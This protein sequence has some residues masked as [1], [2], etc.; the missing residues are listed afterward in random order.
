MRGASD[1]I[2]PALALVLIA[3]LAAGWYLL[4]A[5]E[6]HELGKQVA[7]GAGFIANLVLWSEAGYFD[8]AA[9]TKPLLHLWSLGIE[10]QFYL[11]WPLLLVLA[12]KLRL[13]RLSLVLGITAISLALNI[14]VVGDDRVAAF[15]LPQTRFWELMIGAALAYYTING[16]MRLD[17]LAVMPWRRG[18]PEPASRLNGLISVVGPV[19]IAGAIAFLSDG[20]EFPGWRALVPT[21]GA[22]LVIAS[23]PRA[24]FNQVILGHPVLVFIGLISYPLYLWHWPLLTFGRILSSGTPPLAERIGLVACSVI[25]AYLTYALIER[26]V[27]RSRRPTVVAALLVA[28]TII[29]GFGYDLY[30]PGGAVGRYWLNQTMRSD[31]KAFKSYRSKYAQCSGALAPDKDLYLCLVSRPGAPDSALFGDSH[32]DHLFPGIAKLDQDNGWLLIGQPACPPLAGMRVFTAG[33]KDGCYDV[34]E[35]ALKLIVANR[36]IRRVVLAFFGP[37]YLRDAGSIVP[38]ADQPDPRNWVIEP[39]EARGPGLSRDKAFLRGLDDTVGRLEAADKSVIL[40]VDIPEL[41]FS[42]SDC[43]GR[44]F[45]PAKRPSCAIDRSEVEFA[46]EAISRNSGPVGACP[47]AA[48]L[49]RS[50]R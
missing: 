32:A 10:E 26:Q 8:S 3:C 49:L 35:A 40:Y 4:F 44:G 18:T 21:M 30:L 50:I 36:D 24:W 22:F 38:G 5:E 31:A 14:V 7:G 42:P 11:I 23:G 41:S 13:P 15:Y 1:K 34:T 33:S 9:R 20:S 43:F 2:F 19:L 17:G 6:Y 39:K 48:A 28:M 12:A 27:R 45:L 29:G 46:S 16:G 37:L 47:S 25:L